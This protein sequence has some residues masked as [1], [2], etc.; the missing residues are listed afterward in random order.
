MTN[1]LEQSYLYHV[2]RS[3]DILKNIAIQY[4]DIVVSQNN[5]NIYI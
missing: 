2:L 4:R 3:L 5:I 1:H